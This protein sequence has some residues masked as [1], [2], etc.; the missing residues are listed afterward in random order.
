MPLKNYGILKG[1]P[2]Q[3]R[4]A[5]TSNAHYQ[6]HLVDDHTDYRIAINVRS[7]CY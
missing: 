2:I 3:R 4:L 7:Y 5:V 1:R 6:L